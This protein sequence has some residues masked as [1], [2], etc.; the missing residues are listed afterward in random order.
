MQVLGVIGIAYITGI[1]RGEPTRAHPFQGFVLADRFEQ[2]I[3]GNGRRVFARKSHDSRAL[4]GELPAQLRFV[5][6]F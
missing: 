6:G 1:V 5:I 4:L 3:G 2:L